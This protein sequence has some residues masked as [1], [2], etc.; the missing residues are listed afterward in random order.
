MIEFFSPQRTQR[1]A[2]KNFYLPS[3]SAF[4]APSAVKFH[5][6]TFSMLSITLLDIHDG[7]WFPSSS[8]GTTLVAKLGF[9]QSGSFADRRVPKQEFG[10]EN[11]E[12]RRKTLFPIM[13]NVYYL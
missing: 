13:A 6:I 2:K 3:F 10:N 5:D 7:S 1:N 9:A 4:S 12:E 8:L 11:N